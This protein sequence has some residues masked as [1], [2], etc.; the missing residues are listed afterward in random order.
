M[1]QSVNVA[2]SQKG[3]QMTVQVLSP[4]WWQK[5]AIEDIVDLNRDGDK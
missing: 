4:V 1:N 3:F 2:L 5:G